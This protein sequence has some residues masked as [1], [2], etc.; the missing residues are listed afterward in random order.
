MGWG[1]CLLIECVAVQGGYGVMHHIRYWV[2]GI[3]RVSACCGKVVLVLV[4]WDSRV[5]VVIGW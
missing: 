1:G 4:R 2:A 3:N 5:G